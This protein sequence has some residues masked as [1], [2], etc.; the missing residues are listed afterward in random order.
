MQKTFAIA[1]SI[2]AALLVASGSSSSA[3]VPPPASFPSARLFPGGLVSAVTAPRRAA[4]SAACRKA[5][6]LVC[7]AVEV[8][9]DRSGAV[10][11]TIRLHVE[12]LPNAKG[13]TRGAIF[14][15][16]GGPGQGSAGT[17]DLGDPQHAAFFRNLFPGYTLVAYDDRGTGSSGPLA[18]PG[19]EAATS[20]DQE[21]QLI[22]GCA[23]SLGPRRDF[24]GT[25]DHAEDLEA[26]RQSLGVDRV[27]LWGV[28]YGTKLVL[29]Y[30]LAHP[31]HVER[32]LLDSVVPPEGTDP[33]RASML[34]AMP[35]TL[36]TYCSGGSCRAATPDFAGDVVAVANELEASPLTGRVLEPSGKTTAAQLGARDFLDMVIEADLNPGLAAELPAAV[37]AA[38]VGDPKPLLRTYEL[39]S[40]GGSADAGISPALYLATVCRDGPFPWLPETA[41]ADRPAV[42]QAAVASLPAGSFGPFGSW[43]AV[44]GNAD[45]CLG[46]PSPVGGA[47]VGAGLLPDVPVLAVSGGLDLRT[48]T[49]AAAAVVARFPQGHL[50]VVPGVGHSVLTADPSGC[51]QKAVRAWMLG[52]APPTTCARAKPFV[53]PVG[54]FPVPSSKHLDAGQTR[55]LVAKTVHE[56]EAVWMMTASSGFHL[57]VPGLYSGRLLTTGAGFMLQRYSITPGVTLTGLVL[58]K[59]LGPPLAFEGLLNVGGKTAT[60]GVLNLSGTALRGK[61]G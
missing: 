36:A 20:A 43:A 45:T 57:V 33:F 19:L 25:A 60:P 17:F 4:A 44:L 12:V 31:D 26:V 21:T 50:L 23:A 30:A 13:A 51:S 46:W 18:C 8:P 42:V 24:Y 27:A 11:G 47:A 28:S 34:Q 5:A 59:G 54:A 3:R 53:T 55:L 32:L 40:L 61:L 41:T 7:T 29:A 14:L 15:V 58:L 16:A 6:G 52:H 10:G 1:A 2:A 39:G 22:A 48:P 9:L 38:R 56:A 37:H 49:A 35:A